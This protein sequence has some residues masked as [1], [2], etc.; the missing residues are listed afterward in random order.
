MPP[1]IRTIAA[2]C[3]VLTFV[4]PQA[5]AQI[6]AAMISGVVRDRV[7]REPL[8]AAN[9]RVLGTSR[10]TITNA[11]GRFSLALPAGTYE[12][13]F[14]MLGYA[15]DTV[16]TTVPRD[17]ELMLLLQ[18]SAIVLPEVVVT[19]EDPAVEIIRRAIAN[20]RRWVDRLLN[21]QM[22]AFTRQVLRRDTSVASITEAYTR[23]YWQQ[24]DT[25]REVVLQKRQTRNIQAGF[26]FASVGQILNFNDERVRFVGYSFVGPTALDALD[27]YFYK[28]LRT[29]IS[30]DREVYEIR[31][32]PRSRTT[33]LFT[34]TVHIEGGSYALA[35]I[36]VEPNEAFQLP[37]VRDRKIRYRQQFDLH[38]QTFWLPADIRIDAR[39]RISVPGFSIP[40]IDFSQTSVISGYR[41]N[42]V[43]PDSI[44]RKPRLT[45]DSSATRID[46]SYWAAHQILPLNPEE[47]GAYRTLDSTQSLDVQFRPGGMM[48]SLG[49]DAGTAGSLL[50]YL[51]AAYNRVEGFRL[52]ARVDLE[53]L[54]PVVAVRGG[55]SYGFSSKRSV[56]S[57]G[58]TVF[59]GSDRTLGFGGDVYRRTESVPDHGYYGSLINSLAALF[60]KQDYPDYYLA[61]GWRALV[62]ARPWRTFRMELVIPRR[63]APVTRGP[64]RFQHPL[65]V[66]R[67]PGEPPRRRRAAPQPEARGADR[68]G[69]GPAGFPFPERHRR[70]DRVL[71]AVVRPERLRFRQGGCRRFAFRSHGFRLLSAARIPDPRGRGR[72]VRSG[73]ASAALLPHRIRA[74]GVRAVRGYAGPGP[75]DLCGGRILGAQ[76][77]AQFPESAVPGVGSPVPVREQHRIHRPRRRRPDLVPR[78]CHPADHPRGLLRGGFWRQPPLRAPAGGSHLAPHWSHGYSFH[79]R[80]S[81]SDVALPFLPVVSWRFFRWISP[82]DSL[83]FVFV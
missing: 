71:L 17:D 38:E 29:R 43:I 47:A 82:A 73:A 14:S 36:D 20:K 61:T 12:L 30:Y 46:S 60:A 3:L 42:T 81:E 58:A 37:F 34:G 69:A 21:Y 9:I 76:R 2:V 22:D 49:G 35:G 57:A 23:G 77:G 24:G 78:G 19:S 11:Q 65:P 75:E 41:V 70:R 45:V 68:G 50:Q 33:P 48:M 80:N 67:V 44:F 31:M 83:Y 40:A 25:L 28:L 72:D 4:L 53:K 13:R 66:T 39:V 16:R 63:A 5:C 64:D 62:A 56:Y 79:S 15:P 8:A 32:T 54:F 59:T 74:C 51:D 7:S 52:G 1:Q 6:D 18:P 27:H 26:N 10:G 55:F